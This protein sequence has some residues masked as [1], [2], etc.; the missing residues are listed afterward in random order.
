MCILLGVR[1]DARTIVRQ[2]T[3]GRKNTS[4]KS[5]KQFGP[6]C[7][8][9]A[10]MITRTSSFSRKVTLIRNLLGRVFTSQKLSSHTCF[11]EATGVRQVS[12]WT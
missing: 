4:Q 10:Q 6:P 3:L 1:G 11:F 9:T 12:V 5:L 8:N 2:R 7:K